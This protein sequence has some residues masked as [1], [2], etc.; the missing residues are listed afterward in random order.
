MFR[1][2]F[3]KELREAWWLGLLPLAMM[4]YYSAVEAEFGLTPDFRL[5][6]RHVTRPDDPHAMPLAS[7]SFPL[8]ALLWGCL[9]AGALGLWQTFRESQARTWH[10]L[11][12]RPVD[13]LMILRAKMLAALLVFFVAIAV[14]AVML[15]V[16]AAMPGTHASPFR[17][18]LTHRVWFAIWPRCSQD[19]GEV[20]CLGHDG[21]R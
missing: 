20:I 11:F 19:C 14:P 17:W 4:L 2:L 12:H 9:L 1:A 18:S 13:R 16:W 3:L 6:F 10:F 5:G 15:C 21:G 8:S 7:G